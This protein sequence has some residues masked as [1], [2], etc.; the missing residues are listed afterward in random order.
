[1]I[2]LPADREN[3]VDE[4]RGFALLGIVLVNA[5]FLGISM[6]GFTQASLVSLPDKIAAFA[7]VA[8]A[9]AKFYLLFSFLFGYSLSFMIKA[10][11]P[12]SIVR[13]NRR[14]L[15]LA[16]LGVLHAIFLFLGDILLMYAVLGTSMLWLHNKPDD[17]IR[18]A[19]IAAILLLFLVLLMI[20]IG[21]WLSPNEAKVTAAVKLLDAKLA[22][23]T[24]LQ[25]VD[26]RLE[27]W[28]QVLGLLFAL[29]GAGVLAMFCLGLLSG[30]KRLL[31][32]PLAQRPLWKRGGRYGL[33]IGLPAAFA[34]AYLAVGPG[35]MVDTP[36][37]RETAGVVIGF[38]TAPFL[39]WGYVSWLAQLRER[40]PNLLKW[41]RSAGK[42]SLTGYLAESIFLSLIFCGYGLAWFGKYNAAVTALVALAVWLLVEVFAQLWQRN[43][44]YGPFEWVLSRWVKW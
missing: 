36:G 1:M 11:N 26:A 23:G 12:Q 4:L 34:S 9:Q 2:K 30:R 17:T 15:G 18:K 39:T 42:M 33:L 38:A 21:T 7:V 24:F 40:W 19:I 44:R 31:A 10:E 3:F 35:A 14:L 32:E 13:F 6:Q 41:C 20:L 43:F 5:P 37:L 25:V 8:F 22:S 27:L 29:N 28:P 16:F